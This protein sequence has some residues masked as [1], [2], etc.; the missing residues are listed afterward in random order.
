[1]SSGMS[2]VPESYFVFILRVPMLLSK[3][4]VWEEEGEGSSRERE[5]ERASARGK[6]R[7]QETRVRSME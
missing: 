3:W 7:G 1:M 4:T 2:H 6:E 5:R